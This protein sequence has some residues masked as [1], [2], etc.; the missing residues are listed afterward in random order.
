MTTTLRPIGSESRGPDGQRSRSYAVCVNSRP[1]G[2]VDLGT[3]E[4]FAPGTGRIRQLRIDEPDRRRGRGTVAALAA[5]EVLR[6]WGCSRIEVSIPASAPEALRMARALAYT[7]RNRNM[8]KPVPAGPPALPEGTADRTMTEAEYPAWLEAGKQGYAQSWID[9][10]LSGPQARARSEAAHRALLPDGLATAG[11]VLRVLTHG[12][13]DVGT[14]WLALER[15][16]SDGPGGYV[17]D[18]QVAAEHWGH[19]H[20]RSLMLLAERACRAGGMPRIGLNVFAGNTPALR[21]YASLGYR[22]TRFHLYKPL[23]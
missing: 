21:L 12:G 15:E 1:V 20:G 2:A 5:E 22:A 17:Y 8:A 13:A 10:G 9:R 11:L 19:G 18:V 14:L 4:A 23:M 3:D 7:E 16:L 6:G